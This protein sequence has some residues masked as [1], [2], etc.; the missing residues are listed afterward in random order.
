M[1]NV[2]KKKSTIFWMTYETHRNK[3]D[4]RE[5]FEGKKTLR[6]LHNWVEDQR[7]TIMKSHNVWQDN[8]IMVTNIGMIKENY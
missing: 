2:F 7:N 4:R 3:G 6:D 5:I 8:N 1:F